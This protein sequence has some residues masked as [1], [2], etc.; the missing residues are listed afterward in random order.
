MREETLRAWFFI[1]LGGVAAFVITVV[2]GVRPGWASKAFTVGC[3]AGIVVNAF[4]PGFT[5]IR[6]GLL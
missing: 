3:L 2:L 4:R 5:P 1:G 6:K